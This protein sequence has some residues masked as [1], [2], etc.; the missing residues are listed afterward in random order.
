MATSSEETTW[1]QI[2]LFL[3]TFSSVI[4]CALLLWPFFGAIVG[5]IVLAVITQHPYDWL[6]TKIRNRS[7]AAAL[8][9]ALVLLAF[10]V[11]GFFLAQ[12]I[13]KQ[14]IAVVS[15]VRNDATQEKFSEFLGGHPA[16]ASRVEVVSNSID[17]GHAAQAAA[18]YVGSKIG[19]LLGNSVRLITQ[20]VVMLFLL[21]FL[22]RD[23]SLALTFLHS[24]LPLRTEE[25]SELLTRV[26][27]TIFTTALGRLAVAGVQGVLI[28]L[29]FW[30]LGVPGV[31]L[32]AFTTAVMA[33]IPAFGTLLVWGPIAIY[34]GISGHW[35]KALLLVIWGG[36]IVSTIDNFLYPILVGTRLRSH[37]ATI[38]ISILGGIALFGIM[39][40]ILGPVFFT[41]ASTLLEFWR[42]RT[43]NSS[44]QISS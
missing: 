39:G 2:T 20:L 35:G 28:G 23:R 22:F 29:A 43:G 44:I 4:V 3:L 6:A 24:L 19:G 14:A 11:P 25:S 30:V 5:A 8:G 37:T 9:L 27:D 38:L 10:V 16:A 42:A 12:N 33:M 15:T 18:A 32:W 17:P 31:I 36:V 26:G 40:V 13:G 21:F 1:K 41:I 34:L 7:A